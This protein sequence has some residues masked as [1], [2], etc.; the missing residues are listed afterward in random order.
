MIMAERSVLRIRVS[1]HSLLGLGAFWGLLLFHHPAEAGLVDMLRQAEQAT[2]SGNASQALSLYLGTL[3]E[4]RR[5]PAELRDSALNG[6]FATCQIL[7]H[8]NEFEP[9]LN[10]LEALLPLTRPSVGADSLAV[11][12]RDSL[13]GAAVD[14]LD[15]HRPR[16]AISVL[17]MLLSDGPANPLRYALLS[18]ALIEMHDIE[19]GSDVLRQAQKLYPHAPELLFTQATLAGALAEVAVGRSAYPAA[20]RQLSETASLLEQALRTMPHQP[21]IYHALG[22]LYAALTTVYQATGQ[23]RLAL[24]SQGM[25]EEAYANAVH[26]DPQ[27]PDIA[28]E[29]GGLLFSAQDWAYARELFDEALRRYQARSSANLSTSARAT[30]R[31]NRQH[32]RESIIATY[33]Y[34]TLDAAQAGLFERARTYLDAAMRR[35]PMYAPEASRLRQMFANYER[36]PTVHVA[37]PTTVPVLPDQ[38]REMQVQVGSL[39]VDLIISDQVDVDVLGSL[40][41][42]AHALTEGFFSYRL[43]GP[44]SIRVFSSQRAFGEWLGPRLGGARDSLYVCGRSALYLGPDRSRTTWLRLFRHALARRYIDEMSFM[45]APQWLQEGLSRLASAPWTEADQASFL[46]LARAGGLVSWQELSRLLVEN[47]HE[48]G[49]LEKLNLQAHHITQWLLERYGRERM[50]ILLFSLR[51]GGDLP[52]ATKAAFGLELE[53]LE[54]LWLRELPRWSDGVDSPP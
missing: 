11:K 52:T 8:K 29:F 3:S 19:R 22:K 32:C 30:E 13:H 33:H 54:G 28:F 12:V 46:A 26:V 47:W 20:E 23:T 42:K 10:G 35:F 17:H 1:R 9:A 6:L 37:A 27:R 5:A 40:L 24:Q 16:E 4:I 18:R 21:E 51:A 43:M 25:A 14:L 48:P 53:S 34:Q 7:L 38:P 44:V 36:S 45:R 31:R 15:L 50:T 41:E 2:A 39:A 49:V